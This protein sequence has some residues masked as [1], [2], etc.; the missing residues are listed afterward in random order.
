[1]TNNPPIRDYSPQR[2]ADRLRRTRTAVLL[3][4]TDLSKRSTDCRMAGEDSP[5]DLDAA[6]YLGAGDAYDAA[7]NMLR[8]ILLEGDA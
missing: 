2:D 4:L 7:A 3:A 1:M 6:R 5:N 8:M